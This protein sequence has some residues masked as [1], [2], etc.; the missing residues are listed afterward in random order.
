MYY[1]S[2]MKFLLK[3][4]IT[5]K[6]RLICAM[7]LIASDYGKHIEGPL[8]CKNVHKFSFEQ[9]YKTRIL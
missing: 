3:E 1:F 7:I 6:P 2:F 8:F 4:F 5:I 9:N